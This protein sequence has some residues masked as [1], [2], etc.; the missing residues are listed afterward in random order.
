MKN[1]SPDDFICLDDLQH[2]HP[3]VVRC[4]YARHDNQLLGEAIYKPDA[5]VWAHKDLAAI[6]IK[7]AQ[8]A[9]EA[10]GYTMI[11]YDCLRT[12]TAQD[13]MAQTQRALANPHWMEEPRLLSPPGTG[14][15][16]RGMAIDVSL[17]DKRGILLDMGTPFDL[18]SENSAPEHNPAHREHPYL[19]NHVKA[20]RASLDN[21]MMDAAK[22]LGLELMPLPPRMVGF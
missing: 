2:K 10:H 12:S 17:L 11:L 8:L 19:P 21:A 22:V 5:K 14:A 3:F 20:N 4:D 18:M 9:H 13:K 7:A 15:H 1:L 6:T 16:P